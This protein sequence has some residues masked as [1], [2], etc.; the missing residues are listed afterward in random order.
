MDSTGRQTREQDAM[1]LSCL[2]STLHFEGAK[3]IYVKRDVMKVLFD[4]SKDEPFFVDLQPLVVPCIQCIGWG[5][6]VPSVC[7][8]WSNSADV[9]ETK[10][11]INVMT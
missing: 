8:W 10:Y 7:R 4:P 1:L 5:P 3:T 2:S 9:L 11:T 6:G